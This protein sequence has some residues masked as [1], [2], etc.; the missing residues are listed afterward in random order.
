[1]SFQPVH[2]VDAHEKMNMVVSFAKKL[3]KT[4]KITN[5]PRSSTVNRMMWGFT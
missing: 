4:F 1:M 3:D 5:A 2:K